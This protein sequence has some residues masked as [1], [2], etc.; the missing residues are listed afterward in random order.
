MSADPTRA[1]ELRAQIL[2][3]TR[4][5]AA[6]AFPE[7]PFVHGETIVPVAGRV[8][9]AEEV[10]SLVDSSLDMWLTTGRFAAEFERRFG[11]EV[12]GRRHTVLVNSGSSAN[13]VAASALTSPKLGEKRIAPGSEV[14]TVATGFPTTVNP[15]SRRAPSRCSSTSRSRPTTSTS[16]TS[17]TR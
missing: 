9:D 7:R 14:I 3:L 5:Y 10:V 15:S 1:D 11:K 12:F 17:R 16:P 2:E 6:E 8:F 4:E 13:L